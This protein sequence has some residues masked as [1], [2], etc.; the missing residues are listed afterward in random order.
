M[1]P[2]K[3]AYWILLTHAQQYISDYIIHLTATANYITYH[4]L[5]NG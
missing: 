3:A 4:L 1:C 2:L 5:A